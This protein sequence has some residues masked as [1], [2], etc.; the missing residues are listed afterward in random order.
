MIRVYTLTPNNSH[1]NPQAQKI[2]NRKPRTRVPSNTN[3]LRLAKEQEANSELL[4]S[5]D[6]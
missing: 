5:K 1:Q 4:R 2:S 6:L 3:R